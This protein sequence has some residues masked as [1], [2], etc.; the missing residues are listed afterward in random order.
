MAFT[1]QKIAN[2]TIKNEMQAFRKMPTFRV[3]APAFC[4][5]SSVG[6]VGPFS[7]T[8][9]LVKSMPPISR[10]RIG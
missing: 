1:S 3:T 8:N 5:A 9:R 2:E 6:W 4:A 7:V 10:P